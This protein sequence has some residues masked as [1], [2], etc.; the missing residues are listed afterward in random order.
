V[1]MDRAEGDGG[2]VL[3]STSN[4]A[5]EQQGAVV[6]VPPVVNT[7]LTTLQSILGRMMSQ[8]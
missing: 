1:L 3:I 7:C 5:I 6:T 8:Y 4:F 2:W